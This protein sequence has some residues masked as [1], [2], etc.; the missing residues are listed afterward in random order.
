MSGRGVAADPVFD[1]EYQELVERIGGELRA[2][3]ERAGLTQELLAETVSISRSAIAK[4]EA[5]TN[6]PTID[7]LVALAHA[8][9]VS[10]R[11]LLR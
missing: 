9:N 7:T 2:R 5:G 6:A 3:R 1:R 4:I 8:L 10:A 11:T